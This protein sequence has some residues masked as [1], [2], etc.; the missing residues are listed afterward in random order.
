MDEKK[1]DY[2]SKLKEVWKQKGKRKDNFVILILIGILLLVIVW[3]VP[4]EKNQETEDEAKSVFKDNESDIMISDSSLN[5]KAEDN[6][7]G[8]AAGLEE[9]LEKIL[10]KIEG[11]G[12]VKVMITIRSSEELIVEKDIPLTRSSISEVDAQG[13]SRFSTDI[14]NAEGTIY[15]TDANGTETPYVKQIIQ[16]EIEGVLVVTQGGDNILIRENISEAI[17]AL[18]GID[19][20]KIKIAKMIKE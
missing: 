9:R 8:Y 17:K 11:A 12:D 15:V 1:T 14:D 3:P 10:S 20:H 6:L 13:G 2:L 7:E 18:F 16:P 5:R 19:E 4:G